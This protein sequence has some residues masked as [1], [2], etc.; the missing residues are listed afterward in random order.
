MSRVIF[1][2]ATTR[3][4]A[5]CKATTITMPNA[6]A[7]VMYFYGLIFWLEQEVRLKP[8]HADPSLPC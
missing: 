4:R 7:T 8:Y 3:S 1:S 5:V 2:R 6:V